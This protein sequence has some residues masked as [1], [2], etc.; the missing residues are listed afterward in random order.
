MVMAIALSAVALISDR[1]SIK[2]VTVILSL[3]WLIMAVVA[4]QVQI[5]FE[6]A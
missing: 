5:L 2:I 4:N 6:R 3:V 1:H